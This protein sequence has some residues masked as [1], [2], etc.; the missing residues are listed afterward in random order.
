VWLWSSPGWRFTANQRDGSAD[1]VEVSV[2]SSFDYASANLSKSVSELLEIL[3]IPSVSALPEHSLDVRAAAE[4]TAAALGKIGMEH[5]HL[6]ESDGGNPVVRGDW[7][8]AGT[9]APTLIL[10]GHYD[11]QPPDPIE[12]WLSPPFE[13][14]VAKQ[15]LIRTVGEG[16]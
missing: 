5:V 10:Y 14:E 8:G 7:L 9:G 2:S 1:L 12:E 11:V 13:P 6:A 16:S 3:R 15:V 4:A